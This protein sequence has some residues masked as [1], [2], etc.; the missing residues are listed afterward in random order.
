M[1]VSTKAG[2]GDDEALS[3]ED[4]YHTVYSQLVG[5]LTVVA[6]SRVTAEDAVQ[7]AFVRTTLKWRRIQ[8]YEDPRAWVRRVA[9]NLVY[10][11]HRRRRREVLAD[12]PDRVAPSPPGDLTMTPVGVALAELSLKHRHVLI[13][14]T[15]CDFTIAEIARTLEISESAAKT[16]LH[17]A[18][19]AL[20]EKLEE[21]IAHE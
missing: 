10:D 9:H 12:P 13:L 15:V 1:G 4:L 5:E 20:A 18:R 19:A 8:R 2:I 14:R 3:L 17:R 21:R 6:G 11:H 7:E 16:R